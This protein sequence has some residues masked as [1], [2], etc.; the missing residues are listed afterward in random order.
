[1]EALTLVQTRKVRRMPYDSGA[2]AFLARLD[3]L[4]QEHAGDREDDRPRRRRSDS[5]HRRAG[6]SSKAIFDHYEKRGFEP[7]PEEREAQLNL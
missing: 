5:S 2:C 7:S 3:R 6:R 4:D 1:M